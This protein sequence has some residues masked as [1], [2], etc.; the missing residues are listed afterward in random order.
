[1]QQIYQKLVFIFKVRN[2]CSL[3]RWSTLSDPIVETMIYRRKKDI[4][5]ATGE[6]FA[7]LLKEDAWFQE[8]VPNVSS[9]S[10]I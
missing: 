5:S 6:W 3:N 4:G 7:E 9:L 10:T 8:V 2:H 1:M